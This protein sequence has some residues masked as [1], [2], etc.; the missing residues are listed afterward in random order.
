MR[1]ERNRRTWIDGRWVSD[2]ELLSRKPAF[3]GHTA[4]YHK[5]TLRLLSAGDRRHRNMEN[6]DDDRAT[7]RC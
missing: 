7:M 5:E 2:L 1:D 3:A 4:E 6:D